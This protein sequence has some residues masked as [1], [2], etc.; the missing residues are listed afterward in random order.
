MKRTVYL[1]T[2]FVAQTASP[3]GEVYCY[4]QGTLRTVSCYPV[5]YFTRDFSNR[6]NRNSTLS[7]FYVTAESVHWSTQ[8]AA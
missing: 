8:A 2:E 1:L 3:V 7:G 5:S 4:G 6:R